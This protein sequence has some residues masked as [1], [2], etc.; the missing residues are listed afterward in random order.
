MLDMWSDVFAVPGSRTNGTQ[1]QTFTLV[2][3]KW[4]M[5]MPPIG[6]YGTDYFRRV[7]IAYSGLGANVIEDAIYP[8]AYTNA[9]G[10][11]F[12]SGEK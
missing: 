10:K 2:G 6:T 11:P 7:L 1:E 5:V 3:P 12:I 8:K 9:D 4:G